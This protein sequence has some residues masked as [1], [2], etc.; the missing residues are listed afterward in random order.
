[1]IGANIA[2][3]FPASHEARSFRAV[4]LLDTL[5]RNVRGELTFLFAAV[6]CVLLVTCV[7][8]VHLFL[9]TAA[10]RRVELATR[11][12]LGATRATL[13][14]QTLT[15]SALLA[16]AGGAGGMLLA[17][18]AVPVLVS[19]A[20]PGI[21]RLNEVRIDWHTF[22]FTGGASLAVALM[23]GV[24]ASLPLTMLQPWRSLGSA[25][26][27]VTLEGRRVRRALAVCGIASRSRSSSRRC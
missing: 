3:A 21:P 27:G 9:A 24:A 1:M 16:F 8:V 23:C 10:G 2:Q 20:P 25:R 17:A 11:V 18:W 5:V 6:M 26:S 7:N 14:R 19:I 12:A 22:V 15:E 4:P 13:V